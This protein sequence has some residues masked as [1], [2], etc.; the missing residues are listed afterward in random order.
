MKQAV[1]NIKT[2]LAHKGVSESSSVASRHL[3]TDENLSVL[4]RDH[5]RRSGFVHESPMQRRHFRVG[6]DQNR[7][8]GQVLE[9][10]IFFV[11]Q[12]QTEFECLLCE[13]LKITHVDTD[14]AL[15]IADGDL[16]SV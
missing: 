14:F 10:V 12:P 6:D 3:G 15:Q 8:L 7:S 5:I 13:L 9:F 1:D 2:Q 4:K 11:W 16:R